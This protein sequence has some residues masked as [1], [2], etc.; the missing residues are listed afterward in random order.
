VRFDKQRA[1]TLIELLLVL[2]II[3]IAAAITI[4]NVV[5]SIH[6]HRIRVATRTVVSAGKFARSMAVLNQ[7]DVMLTID[8][9]AGRIDVGSQRAEVS[10]ERALDG[11]AVKAVQIGGGEPVTEGKVTIVYGTQ[12]RCTPYAL[13]LEDAD[14]GRVRVAVDALAGAETERL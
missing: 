5:E 8:V 7:Q 1:F 14:G 4:P 2:A 9:A 13:E 12:G 3:G 11:V 6:G 10:L